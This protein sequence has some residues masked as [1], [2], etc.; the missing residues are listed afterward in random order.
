MSLPGRFDAYRRVEELRQRPL[1]VYAT[2]Q[3]PNVSSP[4]STETL[5]ELFDQIEALPRDARDADVLIVSRGGEPM[6]AW[7]FVNALRERVERFSV[8]VPHDAFSSATLLALGADEIVMHPYGCLGP[9]DVTVAR[10]APG[11][12]GK[13]TAFS[14][15]DLFAY[16]QFG[17]EQLKLTEPKE[18]REF[19]EHFCREVGAV[20]VGVA[21]RAANLSIQLGE[22]LLRLHMKAAEADERVAKISSTLSKGYL[23]HGHPLGRR[24][25]RE[26]GL[27]IVSPEPELERLMRDIW[28]DI[29][30][31]M[32][33]RVPFDPMAELNARPAPPPQAPVQ[34]P[35]GPGAPG[36]RSGRQPEVAVLFELILVV[37]ESVRHATRFVQRGIIR[38]GRTPNGQAMAEVAPISSAWHAMQ[39]PG[40]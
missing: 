30:Q 25:A 6:V 16:T 28:L 37:V 33:C 7:R 34:V 3:R 40:K 35:V 5:P 22:R 26:L 39:A 17:R 21:A 8:L 13:V 4:M 9:V 14:T 1:I 29:E 18:L 32:R 36:G 10:A 20:H 31:E 27:S 23:H 2:S 38:P 11:G 24:E 15:E 19:V 12:G